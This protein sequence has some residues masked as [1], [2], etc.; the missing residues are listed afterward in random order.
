MSNTFNSQ[1]AAAGEEPASRACFD[2]SHVAGELEE[3]RKRL[4]AVFDTVQV[5]I[6]I[7]DAET[8]TI[9]DANPKAVEMIGTGR[10][11]VVGSVCHCFICPEQD[12]HC[13]ITDQGQRIDN[14][15]RQLLRPNGA[16]IT[17][18]KTVARVKLYGR[19]HL[20]ESFLDITDRKRAEEELRESEERYRDILENA[21]DL[22]QSVDAKGNFI[23]VNS[24]WKKTMGYS[25]QDLAS[26][27]IFDVIKPC[28]QSH[29]ATMFDQLKSGAR[30]PRVEVEFVAK[31][32]RSI[33]LEGSINCNTSNGQAIST[34]G[35][36][37]DIT[38]R[39]K[40]EAELTQS[41]D[42]Y[43][44]LF[45][46]APE[47]ILVQSGGRYLCANKQACV[48]L[49]VDRPEELVG[50]SIFSFVDPEFHAMVLERIQR[51]EETGEPSPLRESRMVQK[52][53]T[54]ID[55]EAVATGIVFQGQ[56]AI[57]V[58]IRDI[59]ERKQ[60][61]EQRREL[62]SRLEKMVEEKT[63]HLKEAQ[64]KLIQSE[65]MAT[66]GEV[67]AGAAHELNNPL[68]GILGA[69]QMLRSN[70]LAN[71]IDPDLM[72]GIDVLE[73]IE[74][75]AVRC[76]KIVEDLVRFT[77]QARCNFS[78]MDI[79][80]VLKDTLDI[81]SGPFEE[82]K[83]DVSLDLDPEVPRIEG[84]FVKLLEVYVNL[85]QNAKSA[86]PNGGRIDIS[87]GLV[88]KY[89]EPLQVS[90]V[91]RDDGCGIPPQNLA[92]IFD[93]FFTTKPVGKGPGLGLTVCYGIV[94]RHGGDIDVRSTVGK[95]T[96]VT[97]TVPVRQQKMTAYQ[98]S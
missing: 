21:N 7:I 34:R 5:G 27:N 72:E 85:L 29:C 26:M 6:V 54:V 82:Q 4:S 83:I 57:Q 60:V 3:S 70:A 12:G 73:S 44:K 58:I 8:H 35:I 38:E 46:N 9:V 86:L 41:E 91:I 52:D 47:A 53:G 13:P 18:V 30:I 74:S 75:A 10:E 76:Q 45:E 61:E 19:D 81:M 32:G 64:A 77:T 28:C 15:E 17:V 71:P 56:Q 37:R 42:R 66:L 97:V 16:S 14:A 93:P 69:I 25:D 88:K 89:G 95:G 90:V 55:V 11:E 22:I 50:Q 39:K 1:N 63:R 79:N 59:T 98:A 33:I 62:N 68:A 67:I 96:E 65:K 80:E 94:K 87:T 2:F 24:A 51:I 49:G 20:I 84:D 43:R 36:F 78:D 23:Y 92:K 48:L 40:M 31:D